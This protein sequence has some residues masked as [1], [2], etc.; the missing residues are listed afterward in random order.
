MSCSPA[1]KGTHGGLLAGFLGN[2]I[3]MP[4]VGVSRDPVDPVPL[5]QREA[6]AVQSVP[7]N[8][9]SACTPRVGQTS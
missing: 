7:T 9:C 1:D 8:G 6:Q 5:V 4:I 2:R 3:D